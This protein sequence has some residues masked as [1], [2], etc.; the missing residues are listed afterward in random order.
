LEWLLRLRRERAARP[1]RR[2]GAVPFQ[3]DVRLRVQGVDVVVTYYVTHDR[4]MLV[5]TIEEV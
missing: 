5:M 3:D 1:R 4:L 2:R